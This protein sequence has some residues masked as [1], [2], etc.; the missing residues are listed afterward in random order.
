[1][2][3]RRRTPGR[4]VTYGTTPALLSHFGL[5][6]IGDL[7]GM[8]ELRGAGLLDATM[9]PGFDMPV[10]KVTDELTPDEDP[11]DGD[12]QIPL[13]MHLPEEEPAPEEEQGSGE[14]NS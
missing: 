10:P 2:R 1:M 9:P 4:P 12:E 6:E 11:L 14:P 8:Q 5:N 3:G 13:E 7:P